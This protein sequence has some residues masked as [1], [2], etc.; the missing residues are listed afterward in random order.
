[1]RLHSRGQSLLEFALMAPVFFV[2]LL[3][4]IDFG[5]AVYIY[6]SL[7]DAAREGARAA[8]PAQSPL[9]GNADIVKAINDKLGGG[10]ALTL[11]P[12]VNL[13]TP[14]TSMQN[15]PTAANTGVIW[16]TNPRP[17]GRNGVSVQIVYFFSPWVPLISTV[18]GD[19]LQLRARTTMV[20]EY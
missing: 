4:T 15:P 18:A 20:T 13:P 10:F 12:C 8:V 3:G 11:D 16:F 1:M 6:N 17:V 2:L 9:P 7:A 19:N 14:C 5:R